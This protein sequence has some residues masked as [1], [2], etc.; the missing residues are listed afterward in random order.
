MFICLKLKYYIKKNVPTNYHVFFWGVVFKLSKKLL[1]TKHHSHLPR[2]NLPTLVVSRNLAFFGWITSLGEMAWQ[3]TGGSCWVFEDLF[4]PFFS[5][6]VVFDTWLVGWYMIYVLLRILLM[7][8]CDGDI[9][10]RYSMHIS[11]TFFHVTLHH[12]VYLQL[13]NFSFI[14]VYII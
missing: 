5:A 14:F 11:D 2:A 6:G 9:S 12:D 8:R 7:W 10:S 4:E 13:L 1:P 3:A